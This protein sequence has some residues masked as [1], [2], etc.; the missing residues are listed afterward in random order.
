MK[1]NHFRLF[2]ILIGLLACGGAC[3]GIYYFWNLPAEGH[4]TAGAFSP[5]LSQASDRLEVI[6]AGEPILKLVEAQALVLKTKGA[7]TP[8]AADALAVRINNY[9]RDRF[10]KVP[11]ML[12]L[13]AVAGCAFA[14]F[15]VGLF[16]PLI[17]A[18]KP[19]DIVDLHLEELTPHA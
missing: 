3:Y 2:A 5:P 7:E 12:G 18:L 8:V 14:F 17:A 1:H 16:T 15:L 9:D 6:L 19:P 13:A 10:A 4:W 11:L